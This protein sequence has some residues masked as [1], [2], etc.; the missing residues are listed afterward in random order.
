M[1]T[2]PKPAPD[3]D[4]DAN[5]EALF[6]QPGRAA[7]IRVQESLKTFKLFMLGVAAYYATG[8]S[9][10]KSSGENIGV[11]FEICVLS[12]IVCLAVAVLTAGDLWTSRSV[13]ASKCFSQRG[14]HPPTTTKM[15]TKDNEKSKSTWSWLSKWLLLCWLFRF[16][17]PPLETQKTSSNPPVTIAVH[18]AVE[19][20]KATLAY[21]HTAVRN[22]HEIRF[23]DQA[24]DSPSEQVLDEILRRLKTLTDQA[25]VAPWDQVDQD[26]VSMAIRHFLIDD[27][28]FQIK[29]ERDEW[30]KQHP[31]STPNAI[32]ATDATA[33]WQ[34]FVAAVQAD[35]EL[36]D[37]LPQGPERKIL[38]AALEFEQQRLDQFHEI[39]SMQSVLQKRYPGLTFPLPEIG[40]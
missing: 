21:W 26:L 36:L 6:D 22:L 12:V 29:V 28:F 20:S 1:N 31:P 34:S 18:T 3:S 10:A 13:W 8:N 37:K 27:R 30:L 35:A 9:I 40:Q 24:S 11:V 19:R 15:E 17:S 5:S 2:P 7:W 23:K 25:K 39:E 38:E 16:Q 33:Q 32:S 4:S 14:S